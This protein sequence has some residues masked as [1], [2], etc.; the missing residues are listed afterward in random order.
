MPESCEMEGRNG[1]HTSYDGNGQH[2]YSRQQFPGLESLLPGPGGFSTNLSGQ[3]RPGD[4]WHRESMSFE[5][6]DGFSSH[7]W[8][9]TNAFFPNDRHPGNEHY[10]GGFYQRH[11]PSMTENAHQAFNNPNQ[12]AHTHAHDSFSG[13]A[14]EEVSPSIL[15]QMLLTVP[16]S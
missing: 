1:S 16:A 3:L 11:D 15:L 10:D 8:R 5:A 14:N 7:G 2:N 6:D 9:G 12:E 4:N 13:F